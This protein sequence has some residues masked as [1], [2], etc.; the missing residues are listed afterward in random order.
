MKEM[1]LTP[2]IHKMYQLANKLHTA[3]HLFHQEYY[4]DMSDTNRAVLSMAAGGV[5]VLCT[6]LSVLAS[7]DN[8]RSEWCKNPMS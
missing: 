5:G 7:K 4:S 2:E 1:R 6:G 3:V 8:A